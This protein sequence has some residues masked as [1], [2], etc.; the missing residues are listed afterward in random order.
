MGAFSERAVSI[1]MV[2]IARGAAWSSTDSIA[3]RLIVVLSGSGTAA[4]EPLSYLTAMQAD[5]GESLEISASPE[6]ELFVVGLPNVEVPEAESDQYES[7]GLV[8][9]E[10]PSHHV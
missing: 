8:D 7:E 6:M 5:A 9:E 4:G 10:M 2:K 1:E 3:R